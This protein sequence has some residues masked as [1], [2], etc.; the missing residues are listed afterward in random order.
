MNNRRN[1][2]AVTLLMV[3]SGCAALACSEIRQNVV[4]APSFVLQMLDFRG[5]PLSGAKFLLTQDEAEVRQYT[6][7][8][9]GNI[10]FKTMPA[11]QYT[12]K[13]TDEA[14][15][16]FAV[17]LYVSESQKEDANPVIVRWPQAHVY[18]QK[19]AGT[20]HFFRLEPGVLPNVS[21]DALLREVTFVRKG[22]LSRVRLEL[23][24]A[25]SNN[26]VAQTSTTADG[27]FNF[28]ITRAGLYE[29]RFRYENQASSKLLELDSDPGSE[30]NLDLWLND[31]GS[32]MNGF[33]SVIRGCEN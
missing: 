1:I 9:A 10:V 7:S 5:R 22:P 20:L 21:E 33:V 2:A 6:T 26:K 29:V 18:T 16:F 30:A 12:L 17:D 8:A 24:R 28:R 3:F 32:V 23:F 13:R 19:L 4:T 27:R 14:A 25:G 11:G 15:L 31:R